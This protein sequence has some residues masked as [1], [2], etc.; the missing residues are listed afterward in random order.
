MINT[1]GEWIYT[2]PEIAYELGLSPAT[3]N[4]I[5]KKLYGNKIPHWT[6]DEVRRII[7]YIKSITIEEDEKRLNL[8]RETIKEC[9]YEKQDDK[10]VKKRVS[11]DLYRID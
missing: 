3:V 5:G 4:A 11:K 8:L 6:I 2:N 1:K 9:G 7:E 10:D